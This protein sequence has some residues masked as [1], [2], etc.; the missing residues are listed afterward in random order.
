MCSAAIRTV[1][2][3]EQMSESRWNDAG[4]HPLPRDTPA[5]H[6]GQRTRY[7][8][9]R[10]DHGQ[11]PPVRRPPRWGALPAARG[12]VLQ[13]TS[14]TVGTVITILAG[15]EPGLVL[16]FFLLVGAVA[17]SVAVRPTAVYRIIPVPALAYLAGAVIAGM[18]HDRATDTSRSALAISA[19]QWIAAGFLAMTSATGLVILIGAV[20]WGLHWRRSGDVRRPGQAVA[21]AAA[22][23][24]EA[25][26]RRGRR[27]VAH[28][29]LG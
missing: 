29:R 23:Q 14:V 22:A 10:S 8:S 9:V 24:R 3:T 27:V 11:Q 12:V 4:T 19:A 25:G 18:I 20:R 28:R 16:G 15:I 5:L 7:P 17:A 21:R 1:S 6:P 2:I 26:R 13:L